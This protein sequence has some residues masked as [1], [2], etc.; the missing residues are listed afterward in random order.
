MA[1]VFTPEGTQ[2]KGESMF[3]AEQQV[4]YSGMSMPATVISGPHKSTGADRYLIKKADGLVSLVPFKDLA[5]I[6]DRRGLVA[7]TLYA[8]ITHNK[9][10][11]SALA[12]GTRETYLSWADA[13]L[14]VLDDKKPRPLT[15]GDRIRILRKGLQFASVAVGDVLT[16]SQVDRASFHVDKLRTTGMMRDYWVF[17]LSGEGT[18]WERV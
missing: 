16:V 18:G 1:F 8:S 4:K 17:E 13:V 14:K 9:S 7:Q 5:T 12:Y 10:G 2:D 6:D 11:W 15:V 3:K